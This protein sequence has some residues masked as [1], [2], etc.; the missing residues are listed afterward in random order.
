MKM[1][2]QQTA[3]KVPRLGFVLRGTRIRTSLLWLVLGSLVLNLPAPPSSVYAVSQH[4]QG[5]QYG[6]VID[7]TGNILLADEAFAK[8]AASGAG[9]IRINFRLGNGY[10]VNWTDT[11]AHGYS[12]LSVY[13]SI[14]DN[15]RNR[16]LKILGELSNEAWNGWQSL[17]QANN[18]ETV[19]GGNGDNGYLR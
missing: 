17:W 16:G 9:W 1:W 3:R 18:A 19:A 15:A 14:V 11:T 10:F 7:D 2:S 12:A 6:A 4:N 8:I 13:D 5:L